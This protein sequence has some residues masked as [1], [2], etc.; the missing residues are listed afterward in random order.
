M[1]VSTGAGSTGWVSS[2]FNIAGGIAAFCGGSAG[3]AVKLSWEDQ[4]LLY[5]VRE[6][7]LS[8]HS[9]VGL[10]AGMLE[11]GEELI[12]ESLM[13]TAG[14]VF[15]DGVESDFLHFNSGFIARVHAAD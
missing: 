10:V 3:Q 15:S 12:L 11:Q 14:V 5:V 4:R 2:A 9:Q 8:R 1:L 7:F 6:P 13:P